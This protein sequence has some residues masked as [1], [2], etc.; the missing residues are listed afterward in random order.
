MVIGLF[1][2]KHFPLI[3]HMKW[4]SLFSEIDAFHSW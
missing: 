3:P 2:N 1:V 4:K